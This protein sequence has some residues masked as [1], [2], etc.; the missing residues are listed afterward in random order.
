MAL[1]HLSP[2]Q[3]GER[4]S[5]SES[6]AVPRDLC[7]RGSCGLKENWV[8]QPAFIVSCVYTRVS[9]VPYRVVG[10]FG[11][12]R[13]ALV[14]LAHPRF[15]FFTRAEKCRV[16]G[17]SCAMAQKLCRQHCGNSNYTNNNRANNCANKQLHQQ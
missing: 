17:R 8:W 7:R 15:S 5:E 11:W 6:R 12:V 1:S 13:C 10:R 9:D 16:V 14:G 3:L 2:S 4:E